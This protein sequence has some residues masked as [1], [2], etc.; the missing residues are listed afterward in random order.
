M[1]LETPAP[2]RFGFGVIE[3]ER[4]EEKEGKS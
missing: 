1:D 2:T 3:E 4:E